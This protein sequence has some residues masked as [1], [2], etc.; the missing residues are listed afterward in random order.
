MT[1][2]ATVSSVPYNSNVCFSNS[3]IAV[4]NDQNRNLF[5]QATYN[6]NGLGQNGFVFTDNTAQ[7]DGNFTSI[8]VISSCRFSGISANSVSTVGNLTNYTLPQN[9]VLS[10]PI[11]N[12]KLSFGAVIAYKA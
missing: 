12:F 6:V 5:A 9:F 10:G 3:W 7:V 1:L 4:N 2:T 11:T 8:Q